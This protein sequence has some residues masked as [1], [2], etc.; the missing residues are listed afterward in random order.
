MF[1]LM[2]AGKIIPLEV[3]RLLVL[4]SVYLPVNLLCWVL[5]GRRFRSMEMLGGTGVVCP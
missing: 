5:F 4:V 2:V 1:G 3:L